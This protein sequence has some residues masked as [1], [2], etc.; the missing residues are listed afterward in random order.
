MTD[1]ET[2]RLIAWSRELTRVHATLRRALMVARYALDDAEATPSAARDLLLYCR[3]FCVALDGHHRGEDRHLFPA[4]AASHPQ[5]RPALRA[6][7]QDHSM[8]AHLLGGL[9]SAVERSATL[10]ELSG[11]L[12]GIAA[13][14]ESHFRYEGGGC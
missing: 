1:R 4:I 5:L 14:M 13:I 11:H 9:Q 2:T 3:G 7:E 8:I 12:E 6:L 10:D